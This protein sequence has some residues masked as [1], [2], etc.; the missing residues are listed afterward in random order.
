MRR[1]TKSLGSSSGRL[2]LICLKPLSKNP[3][4]T[5]PW[6]CRPCNSFCPKGPSVMRR[7]ALRSSNKNGRSKSS[8]SGRSI[9]PNLDRDGATRSTAPSCSACISSW[10][11]YNCALGNT[12]TP[13]RPCVRCSSSVLKRMAARPFGVS[14]VTT[15]EKRRVTSGLSLPWARRGRTALH[16][17]VDSN[18]RRCIRYMFRI[19]V[20]WS[21]GL[22]V[23]QCRHSASC[24]FAR[25]RHAVL[26]PGRQF[27]P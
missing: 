5:S 14:S 24:R 10:S 13:M 25:P 27:G 4:P 17:S 12:C 23:R 26:F 7:T 22:P 21:A 8:N 6:R 9:R 2:A 3:R 20:T 16:A 15:W 1:F 19:S 11:P 18:A